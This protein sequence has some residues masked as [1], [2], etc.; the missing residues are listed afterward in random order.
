LRSGNGGTITNQGQWNDSA[1]YEFNNDYLGNSS[2]FLNAA[3]GT[4]QKTSGSTNFFIPLINSGTVTVTGGTLSLQAGGTFN[5]GSTIIANST[6]TL[7]TVAASATVAQL[8]AG[9]LTA[10]GTVN[11]TNFLL[12]GGRLA[13]DQT[14]KG[15][16][17]W[18]NGDLNTTNTTTIGAGA[19]LTIS[20]SSDHD[21]NTHALVNNG[22]V[23]WTGGRLRSG[24]GGTITNQALWT[25]SASYELNNDYL[26]NSSS[27]VN[28]ANGTYKKT[29]GTTNFFI[30]L[31]NSGIVSVSDGT[32]SLQVG[33]TFNSGSTIG[34]TGSGTVQLAAGT[35]TANGTVNV[36]NFLIAGG[37]LAGN[38][39]FSGSLSW[40]GG[41]M[42]TA[43]TTTIGTGAVFAIGGGA[44]HDYNAHTLVNNGTVNWTGGRLSS[45]NGGSIVNAGTWND[46]ASSQ[47]NNDY[48]G[49]SAT[50]TNRGTYA[51]SA[52]GTTTFSIPFANEH[53][54]V[55]VS[56]GTLYFA[57]TYTQ[58]GGTLNVSNGGAL[59]F[60]TGLDLGTATLG[61]TGTITAP[62]VTAGGLV[63]P[64]N[65][66]G[67]LTLSGDLTL[68]AMSS[69]VIELAGTVQ[70][71]S[72]DF[73][74]VGGN[75]TLAGNLSVSLLRGFQGS[76]AAGNTL[77]VLTA[78]NLS[79]V[80]AN[81][82]N[83]QRL[84]TSDGFGSFTVNYGAS[85]AFGVNSVV[86]AN[87]TPVPE[88][89]TYALLAVGL[90]AL[91][92]ARRRR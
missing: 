13:G 12:N 18:L 20:G 50:F 1:S 80:F 78:A 3:N 65:S 33:G 56:A 47:L 61:G 63:S 40:L 28:A 32:L 2:S 14:F 62:S 34:S 71:T 39:V 73:L 74:S 37:Q 69:L 17:T 42:N 92:I 89:S 7:N 66:P 24:N 87:F 15:T 26:G 68:L 85:S 5:D 29:S 51:K 9:T 64:G 30:P 77:T 48:L 45:G 6:T 54:T 58:N 55:S 35:L 76:I 57:S 70:G 8:A 43:V 84:Y 67:K 88:P 10:S 53:G 21:Y 86:L 38:P 81:V 36:S 49:N 44:D 60:D 72:Y 41:D 22:T 4:Y 16:L 27:F 52:A 19:V 82:A 59:Q 25:D 75:A 90:A 46:T 31:V 23:N 79:G 83:G 11:V 91:V